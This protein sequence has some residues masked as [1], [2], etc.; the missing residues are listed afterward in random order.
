ML[1]VTR[2]YHTQKEHPDDRRLNLHLLL[3]LLLY[4]FHYNYQIHLSFYYQKKRNSTSSAPKPAFFAISTISLYSFP[5]VIN[6][7]KEYF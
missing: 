5:L 1:Q 2:N 7:Q 6:V 4:L 3:L